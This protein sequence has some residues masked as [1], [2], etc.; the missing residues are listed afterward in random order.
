MVDS[1]DSDSGCFEIRQNKKPMKRKHDGEEEISGTEAML[2]R[3]KQPKK[4]T[5]PFL[6]SSS[7]TSKMI[8]TKNH[9]L[10]IL[11]GIVD[12]EK[13]KGFS[14][15]RDWDVFY[16][17]VKG[18]I[19]ADFSKA[20]L[21][22]K[23]K[24]LKKRFSD[25]NA[26]SKDG[27]GLSFTSTDDEQ[28]FMLLKNIWGK[29]ETECASNEDMQEEDQPKEVIVSVKDVPCADHEPTR[30]EK[31]DKCE[32]EDG[33]V[34]EFCVLQDALEGMTVFK[35]FGKNQQKMLCRNLKN[36]PA[37]RKKELTDEWKALFDEEMELNIKKLSFSAKLANASA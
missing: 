2:R 27:K 7:P 3:R 14:Y 18:L 26:R 24:K 33:V 31:E 12:Y 37:Q 5:T 6:Y 20:Q 22:N 17:Y 16:G 35:T 13:E 15:R 36:L 25:I 28:V 29:N 32:E 8:W 34:D 9:E 11:K 1:S 23:V 30:M 4:N 21:V 19:D 10:V